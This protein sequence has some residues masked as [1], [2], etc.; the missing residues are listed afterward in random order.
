MPEYDWWSLRRLGPPT[1]LRRA[2]ALAVAPRPWLVTD[3]LFA[4]RDLLPCDVTL[5]LD[6]P[7]ETACRRAA[8]RAVRHGQEPDLAT[9]LA[10]YTAWAARLEPMVARLR[11]ESDI[12]VASP[13]HARAALR[14]VL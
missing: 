14:G 7:F 10:R 1:D 6:V 9:A 4:G 3:G 8:A 12:V 2:R 11:E 5:H 13:A